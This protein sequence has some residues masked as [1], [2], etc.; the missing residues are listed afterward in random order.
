MLKTENTM[1][2][3]A[4]FAKSNALECSNGYEFS[5]PVNRHAKSDPGSVNRFTDKAYIIAHLSL[6]K[7]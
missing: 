6:L 2:L 5:K 1:Y 3:I 4:K 7:L